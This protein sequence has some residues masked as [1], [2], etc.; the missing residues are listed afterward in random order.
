MNDWGRRHNDDPT[1][2]WRR[3]WQS[4]SVPLVIFLFVLIAGAILW[5]LS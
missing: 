5:V 1:P 3:V 4:D 2:P